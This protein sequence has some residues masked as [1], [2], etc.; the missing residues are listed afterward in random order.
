LK[1]ELSWS[2][3]GTPLTHHRYLATSTL[4]GYGYE[5]SVSD[6]LWGRPGWKSGRPGLYL[7]GAFTRPSHG[8]LTSLLNG[9]GVGERVLAMATRAP[10]ATQLSTGVLSQKSDARASSSPC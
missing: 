5:A 7:A 4:G 3:L 2:E 8:I 10:K 6:V 9:V 1:G